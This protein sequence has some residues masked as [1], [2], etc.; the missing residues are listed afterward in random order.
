MKNYF[1]LMG[2]TMFF[3]NKA[4]FSPTLLSPTSITVVF[5]LTHWNHHLRAFRYT[6]AWVTSR[7]IDLIVLCYRL[8]I[9]M[10]ISSHV[11]VIISQGCMPLLLWEGMLISSLKPNTTDWNWYEF[12]PCLMW[13]IETVFPLKIEWNPNA[14][15]LWMWPYLALESSQL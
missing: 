13:W 1:D 8:R 10:F 2:E 11:I 3:N 4:S 9:G 7:D 12:I 14:W 6:D 5:K 15:Y